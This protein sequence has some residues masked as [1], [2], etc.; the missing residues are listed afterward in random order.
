MSLI[1][2]ALRKSEAERRLGSAPELLTAM[3]VLRM[4]APRAHWPLAMTAALALVAALGLGWWLMRSATTPR[5]IAVAARASKEVSAADGAD[6]ATMHAHRDAQPSPR[7]PGTSQ[8]VSTNAPPLSGM[9]RIAEP[10]RRNVV[11]SVPPITPSLAP[12]KLVIEPVPFNAAPGATASSPAPTMPAPSASVAE[13]ALLSLA[14]LSID[15]RNGLPALK[16]S[17]HVY[18]D[19]PAR[20]FMII[21][22]QRVG[23]G[24]RLADGVILVRIRR[25]GAE[26]DA[27]GRR[28]L[29]SKP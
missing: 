13:P 12:S 11:A 26:L 19:D 25:D 10:N 15:E 6:N 1:L 24:A 17:M 27:H 9:P 4:P 14:D 28:M 8:I 20:R 2:E 18:A 16:V 3:P 5:A 23:E 21:D 7:D 29:L 22:G